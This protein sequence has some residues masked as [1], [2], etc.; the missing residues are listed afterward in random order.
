MKHVYLYSKRIPI[1]QNELCESNKIV[2]EDSKMLKDSAILITYDNADSLKEALGLCDAAGYDVR[3]I[4]QHRFL[5]K[6][7][8]GLGE[9]KVEEL[10]EMLST[11]KPDV[12]IF[13]EILKP[14]PNYHLASPLKINITSKN[15]AVKI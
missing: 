2:R 12:I 3:R 7:K 1:K 8:Y 5:N 4:I 11:V 14:S 13:D 15:G 10:K 6:S 9:G